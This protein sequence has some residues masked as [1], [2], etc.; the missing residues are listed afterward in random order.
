[1]HE[2]IWKL[3][4]RSWVSGNGGQNASKLGM[5]KLVSDFTELLCTSGGSLIYKY[6]FSSL[7]VFM[8]TVWTEVL[9]HSCHAANLWTKGRKTGIRKR[10]LNKIFFTVNW[11][12]KTVWCEE[13]PGS[14]K[15]RCS[16]RLVICSQDMRS[17]LC[18]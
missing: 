3:S 14:G 15:G 5:K 17:S 2:V 4:R 7:A 6:P 9:P 11:G 10:H 12:R 1:M 8:E 18:H 16:F 13:V